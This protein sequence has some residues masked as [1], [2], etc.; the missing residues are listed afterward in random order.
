MEHGA[1]GVR[2]AGTEGSGRRGAVR[3]CRIEGRK[4]RE[5]ESAAGLRADGR[6]RI[7]ER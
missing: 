2:D 6:G 4:Y 3:N 7:G 1:G 5:Y